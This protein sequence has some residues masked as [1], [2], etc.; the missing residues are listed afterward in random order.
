MDYS[1][2]KGKMYLTDGRLQRLGDRIHSIE[3]ELEVMRA[4]LYHIDIIFC[5]MQETIRLNER[6]RRREQEETEC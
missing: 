3:T 1:V 4:Q 5:K 2:L 6:R